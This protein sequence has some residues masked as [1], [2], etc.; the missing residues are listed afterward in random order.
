MG[1]EH[2]E[3]PVL[4]GR[5]DVERGP[6]VRMRGR[7][8]ADNAGSRVAMVSFPPYCRI[9]LR[10]YRASDRT[11]RPVWDQERAFLQQ[12]GGCKLPSRPI[13]IP[14]GERREAEGMWSSARDVLG[15]SLPQGEYWFSV[16]AYFPGSSR[17]PVVLPAGSMLL[18]W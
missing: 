5:V 17:Q 10:A 15:D 1:V 12:A 14:P 13:D 18:A 6:P 16:A 7:V 4:A 11:G 2:A 8:T 3:G 9:Y